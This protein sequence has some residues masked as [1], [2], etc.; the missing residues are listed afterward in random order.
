M[1]VVHVGYVLHD[2][3]MSQGPVKAGEHIFVD[4]HK[5]NRSVCP[6]VVYGD[7][8][9]NDVLNRPGRSPLLTMSRFSATCP[10]TW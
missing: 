1:K 9:L 2:V 10:T 8:T 3:K 4:V 5:A 6:T 7:I